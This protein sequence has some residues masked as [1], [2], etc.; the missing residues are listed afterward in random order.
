MIKKKERKKRQ[1]PSYSP[2]PATY[3]C[4]LCLLGTSGAIPGERS[5]HLKTPDMNAWGTNRFLS[6]ITETEAYALSQLPVI[7]GPDNSISKT[8]SYTIGQLEKRLL[9]SPKNS[10]FKKLI[11]WIKRKGSESTFSNNIY[12]YW[13]PANQTKLS[14]KLLWKIHLMIST[15]IALFKER[16]LGKNIADGIGNLVNSDV[17]EIP[18]FFDKSLK[19]CSDKCVL[20]WN[21]N[22]RMSYFQRPLGKQYKGD[23]N[24]ADLRVSLW[25]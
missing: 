19:F 24:T 21:S 20:T 22:H 5:L 7:S 11:Q 6:E 23:P 25:E 3:L 18:P 1:W 4:L 14:Q 17:W 2:F 13:I 9:L 8:L 10:A 15:V 16:C 12:F